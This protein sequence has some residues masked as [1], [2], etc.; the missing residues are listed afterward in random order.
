MFRAHPPASR[1]HTRSAAAGQAYKRLDSRPRRCRSPCEDERRYQE[2]QRQKQEVQHRVRQQ[3][4]VLASL[5]ENILDFYYT[6][7]IRYEPL[8]L[9]LHNNNAARASG[10]PAVSGNL[11][12]IF[13]EL[14][15]KGAAMANI[16][17]GTTA[18]TPSAI[19]TKTRYYYDSALMRLFREVAIQERD[20]AQQYAVEEANVSATE[21]QIQVDIV[22]GTLASQLRTE[23]S[24][25]AV[26]DKLNTTL[27]VLRSE[28]DEIASGIQLAESHIEATEK[29]VEA[30]H[31]RKALLEAKKQEQ[32]DNAEKIKDEVAAFR[33]SV[34]AAARDLEKR[35]LINKSLE[36]EIARRRNLLRRRRKE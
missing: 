24:T 3:Q 13:P 12:S 22:D 16:A 27:T 11:L 14:K 7:T 29:A 2:L 8:L 19:P 34:E 6:H 5:E 15:E 17:D 1:E 20:L 9:Q 36:D 35:L 31:R 32:M 10:A 25:R 4:E 23:Q 26:L 33:G 28:C 18:S 30:C 21:Q